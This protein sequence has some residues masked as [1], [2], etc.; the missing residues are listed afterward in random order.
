MP[1]LTFENFRA[2]NI[3]RMRRWHSI[4]TEPW[5][6]ADWGN[7]LAGEVGEACNIIK[8]IR[9]IE[10]GTPGR[11]NKGKEYYLKALAH[12]LADVYCYL[13]IV[14]D[15]YDIELPAAIV[16]KFNLISDELGFPER[17]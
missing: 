11:K 10:T 13:D 16:E 6:G 9:R 3:S 15:Y 12:E 14:A 17:L 5:N 7:A 2:K 4:A 1:K 8:K